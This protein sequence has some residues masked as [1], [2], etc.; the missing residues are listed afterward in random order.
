MNDIR[1]NNFFISGVRLGY[2]QESNLGFFLKYKPQKVS[3]KY[4]SSLLPSNC[5]SDNSVPPGSGDKT[6][7]PK[8]VFPVNI[9]ASSH[10][11]F[12]RK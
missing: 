7:L 8:A 4:T 12:W 2:G 5:F 9:L 6:P 11:P 3:F 1:N 10:R